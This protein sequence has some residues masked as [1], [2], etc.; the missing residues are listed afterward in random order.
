MRRNGAFTVPE[1]ARTHARTLTQQQQFDFSGRFLSVFTQ[2][3][4]DY[5]APLDRR[6][7]LCAQGATHLHLKPARCFNQHARRLTRTQ[8]ARAARAARARIYPAAGVCARTIRLTQQR[9]WLALPIL[10]RERVEMPSSEI[11]TL[12]HQTLLSFFFLFEKW[13]V[14]IRTAS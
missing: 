2:V 10:T 8:K 14:K 4:I 3:P 12:K 5:F 7:I 11:K 9:R 13:C 6:F 1:H